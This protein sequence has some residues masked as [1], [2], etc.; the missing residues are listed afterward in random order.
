MPAIGSCD[1]SYTKKTQLLDN[2]HQCKNTNRKRN[3]KILLRKG[4]EKEE[5]VY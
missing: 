1:I 4:K 2:S 5:N 3:S